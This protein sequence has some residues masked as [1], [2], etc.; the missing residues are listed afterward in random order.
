MAILTVPTDSL[1]SYVQTCSFEGSKYI[2]ALQYNQ[3]CAA[4]YLSIADADN[5][6]IANGIKLITGFPLLAKCKDP[7][8]PPGD[9]FVL[10]STSDLSPPSQPDLLPGSGRCSLVYVSSDWI[11]QL[12]AALAA[13]GGQPGQGFAA[14]MASLQ[15]ATSAGAGDPAQMSSYGQPGGN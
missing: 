3:R 5:V 6:D 15:A 9:L 7:R 4:W 10:S 12:G 14:A 13:D 1:P 2:L 8:R 11:K